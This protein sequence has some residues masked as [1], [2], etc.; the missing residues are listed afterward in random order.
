MKSIR[1]R[2]EGVGEG[3]EERKWEEKGKGEEEGEWEG[4]GKGEREGEGEGDG[5]GS[6]EKG[7]N[8][9]ITP[10]GRLGLSGSTHQQ[11]L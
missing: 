8:I 11:L 10:V 7:R 5:K 4:E 6:V 2:L 1:S 3:L 9:K